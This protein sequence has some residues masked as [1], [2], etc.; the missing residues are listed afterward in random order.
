MIINQL[1][2]TPTY[3]LNLKG[4]LLS[5]F[6]EYENLLKISFLL[7]NEYKLNQITQNIYK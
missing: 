2:N 6:H 4:N 5:S 1:I 7:T 3:K